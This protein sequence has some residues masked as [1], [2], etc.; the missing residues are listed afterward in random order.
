MAGPAESALDGRIRHPG[1]VSTWVGDPPPAW[2]VVAPALPGPPPRTWYLIIINQ[3][4]MFG[5]VLLKFNS[6]HINVPLNVWSTKCRLI[7]CMST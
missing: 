5:L 7:A 2:P 1:T 6:H 3:S 4:A